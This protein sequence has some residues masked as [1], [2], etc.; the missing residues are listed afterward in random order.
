[1]KTWLT[2][3]FILAV[4]TAAT[5]ASF[6]ATEQCPHSQKLKELSSTSSLPTLTIGTTYEA[7]TYNTTKEEFIWIKVPGLGSRWTYAR[8]GSAEGEIGH[9]NTVKKT[10]HTPGEFDYYKLA[11]SYSPEFCIS[12]DDY[13]QD[14]CSRD[15]IVHGLWP[16]YYDSTEKGYPLECATL[17]DAFDEIDTA[18]V[19]QYMPS[20]F[21]IGHEW[22]RHGTCSGLK[23]SEYF[24]LTEKLWQTLTLPRLQHRQ[25]SAKELKGHIIAPNKQL[26]SEMIEIACDENRSF[27]KASNDTLD[28]IRIC[29]DRS[30][31]PMACTE[32]EQSCS[33]ERIMVRTIAGG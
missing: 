9:N 1:M 2:L 21:L 22:K 30:G 28:E 29:F 15:W 14:Q 31:E 17:P 23:R 24:A 26:N 27:R 7:L 12:K 13:K 18:M 11:I 5:A 19:W 33:T 20:D 8:C 3:L 6:T 4:P 32:H 10:E 25:Y 16:Q